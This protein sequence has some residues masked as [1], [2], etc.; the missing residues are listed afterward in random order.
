[1]DYLAFQVTDKSSAIV[2][3]P[4]SLA[5]NATEQDAIDF[6]GVRDVVF[7]EDTMSNRI[8]YGVDPKESY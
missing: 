2:L 7:V 1:M 3:K 6:F 8:S 4:L 5:Q